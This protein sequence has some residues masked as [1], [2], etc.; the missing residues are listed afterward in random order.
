MHRADDN[1]LIVKLLDF[2]VAKVKMEQAT[3]SGNQSLTRTGS[4]LGSPMYMAPEQAR[5]LKSIDHRVDIWCVGVVLFKLL[6]GEAPNAGAQGLGEL[7][8]AICGTAPS[9]VRD[10]A[11]WVSEELAAIVAR[12]LSLSPAD[13]YQSAA[14]LR[15]DL[16]ALLPGG[17]CR[18]TSDMLVGHE[19]D[20]AGGD[21][22]VDEM[23]EALDATIMQKNREKSAMKK[24]DGEWE[25]TIALGEGE[26]LETTSAMEESSER[27]TMPKVEQATPEPPRP[28][29]PPRPT[30]S[31][32][33]G[34]S[35]AKVNEQPDAAEDSSLEATVPVS[36]ESAIDATVVMGDATVAMGEGTVVMGEGTVVMEEA[37]EAPLSEPERSSEADAAPVSSGDAEV[38]S[39]TP[40]EKV[41][42]VEPDAQGSGGGLR[43]VIL[44]L[45]VGVGL[46]GLGL[47]AYIATF[48][49]GQDEGAVDAS[50]PVLADSNPP[51]RSSE[52]PP[53][54]RATAAPASGETATTASRAQPAEVG[55]PADRAEPAGSAAPA[56]SAAVIASAAP[57]GAAAGE[58]RVKVVPPFAGVVVAGKR[59][60]LQGGYLTLTGK[61]G[62]VI[63][64][65]VTVGGRSRIALVTLSAAGPKPAA[66]HFAAL[67]ARSTPGAAAAP[68]HDVY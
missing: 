59:S 46:G 57:E 14:D 61:T 43:S 53:A 39:S 30:S 31:S 67:R 13:R 15:V 58:I 54:V 38:E 26:S 9:D 12:C 27:T 55:T 68:A 3:N 42:S 17:D 40:S 22:V 5:G 51:D 66:I 35:D 1:E 52:P 24:E 65:R 23:M 49:Q 34:A 32:S 28:P 29:R 25:A 8:L 56:D 11:P 44:A 60:S 41:V 37:D 2:G 64:I 21:A 36:K 63:R 33:P 16:C 62:D 4:L 47:S 6:S 18:I 50:S 48:G 45:V 10:G 20:A 7:V 19:D